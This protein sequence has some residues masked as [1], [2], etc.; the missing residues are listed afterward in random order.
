M[1]STQIG[2]WDEVTRHQYKFCINLEL[3]DRPYS[4]SPMAEIH[5]PDNEMPSKL[6]PIHESLGPT[7][8]KS[9]VTVAKFSPL[10]NS[11]AIGYE[12]GLVE[13]SV[14]ESYC[15]YPEP[16]LLSIQ[17]YELVDKDWV[18]FYT[19]SRTDAPLQDTAVVQESPVGSILWHPILAQDMLVGFQDGSAHAISFLD[20]SGG[21]SRSD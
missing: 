16:N 8:N 2:I 19:F 6:P 21:V 3:A 12:D 9:L 5:P 1:E 17:I 15:V 13:V 7:S 20:Q 18:C 10:D 11:L 14:S 4:T